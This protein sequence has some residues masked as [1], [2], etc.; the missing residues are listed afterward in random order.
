MNNVLT[1]SL[2]TDLYHPDLWM[3]II[4]VNDQL[5]SRGFSIINKQ[6]IIL[7]IS[8]HMSNSR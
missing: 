7:F 1:N 5:P 6:N 3:A 8:M 2:G 4:Q